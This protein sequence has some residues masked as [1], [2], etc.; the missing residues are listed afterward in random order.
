MVTY[1]A[2]GIYPI[3]TQADTLNTVAEAKEGNNVKGLR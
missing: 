2:P 1:A 3:W